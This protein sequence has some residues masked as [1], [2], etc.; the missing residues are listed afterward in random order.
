MCV[1]LYVKRVRNIS[2]GYDSSTID[3]KS[4]HVSVLRKALLR[5]FRLIL[6]IF[7]FS[8]CWFQFV[9]FLYK[10]VE[11]TMFLLDHEKR[12]RKWRLFV[13]IP[14]FSNQSFYFSSRA[15]SSKPIVLGCWNK[16][17]FRSSRT[18]FRMIR[19]LSNNRKCTVE[20]R[21]TSDHSIRENRTILSHHR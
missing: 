8:L 3:G 19:F 4:I 15:F 20:D 17:N 18:A 14:F 13:F 10:E 5:S 2:E 9:N 7:V 6:G 11:S 21:F 16:Q 1:R 12:I